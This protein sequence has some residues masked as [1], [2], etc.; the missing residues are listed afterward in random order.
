MRTSIFRGSSEDQILMHVFRHHFLTVCLRGARSGSLSAWT[1]LLSAVLT[2]FVIAG[3]LSK[4]V[5]SKN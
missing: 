2:F 4:T 3:G 1:G 5:S